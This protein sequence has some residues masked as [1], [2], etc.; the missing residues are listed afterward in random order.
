MQFL[1]YGLSAAL[2]LILLASAMMSELYR[3]RA[4]DA[5]LIE[6]SG[7]VSAASVAYLGTDRT[8]TFGKR[9]TAVADW[10]AAVQQAPIG[11]K[12]SVTASGIKALELQ[13][14]ATPTDGNAWLALASFRQSAG[15]YG[16]PVEMAL[17]MSYFTARRELFV[18]GL[19]SYFSLSLWSVLPDD[20]QREARWEIAALCEPG[21]D[22][23]ILRNLARAA[24]AAGPAQVEL[25]SSIA[26]ET[27][28]FSRQLFDQYAKDL[29]KDLQEVRKPDK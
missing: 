26:G 24:V 12:A 22:L 7:L 18:M 11:Q 28:P 20:L 15:G 3:P 2:G 21:R 4:P 25:V 6:R 27:A 17:R 29:Q 1:R 23:A 10:L 9:R 5:P 8:T 16:A 13:L 19:R 14:S